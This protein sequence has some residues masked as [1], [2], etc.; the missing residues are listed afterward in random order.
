MKCWIPVL[1]LDMLWLILTRTPQE[2]DSLGYLNAIM[3]SI[4]T[5]AAAVALLSASGI[6]AVT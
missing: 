1:K 5:I 4:L 3:H 6:T 2:K